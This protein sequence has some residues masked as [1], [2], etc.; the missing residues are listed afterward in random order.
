MDFDLQVASSG[1]RL[2]GIG[3]VDHHA[4]PR[5]AARSGQDHD[6]DRFVARFARGV[7]RFSR[8]GKPLELLID[9]STHAR[10][11][12]HKGDTSQRPIATC[13]QRPRNVVQPTTAHPAE[14]LARVVVAFRQSQREMQSVVGQQRRL[15]TAGAGFTQFVTISVERD[16]L[17]GTIGIVRFS[18]DAV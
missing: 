14:N 3:K 1:S 15:P 6:S 17:G 9:E 11:M 8:G 13:F 10:S 7:S 18:A 12:V 2:D 16:R 4:G 5:A